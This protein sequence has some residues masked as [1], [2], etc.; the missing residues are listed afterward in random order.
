MPVIGILYI[1]QGQDEIMKYFNGIILTVF[2]VILTSCFS[3]FFPENEET[4]KGIMRPHTTYVEFRNDSGIYNIHGV[5]V[6]LT[7]DRSDQHPIK[8]DAF[9]KSDPVHMDPIHRFNYYFSYILRIEG[10]DIRYEL[11]SKYGLGMDEAYVPR[12]V[13]TSI[14]IPTIFNKMEDS[15]LLYEIDDPLVSDTYFAIYN[16]TS[17]SINFVVLDQS[18]PFHDAPTSVPHNQFTTHVYK[19]TQNQFTAVNSPATGVRITGAY[20]IIALNMNTTG[21]TFQRGYF[22]NITFTPGTITITD[23]KPINFANTGEM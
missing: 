23:S 18:Q 5:W 9:S 6:F 14:H 19:L 8:I 11:P 3:G 16:N 22:Y 12:N 7:P 4:I 10:I 15:K 2:F 1:F 21:E 20:Q 17:S 13:L